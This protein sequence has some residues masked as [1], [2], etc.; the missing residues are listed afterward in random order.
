VVV[1]RTVPALFF[2]T[3][4]EKVHATVFA[5]ASGNVPVT[6]SLR[7]TCIVVILWMA[8]DGNLRLLLR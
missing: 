5:N 2:G 4:S 3:A 7:G 1:L 6:G 8:A